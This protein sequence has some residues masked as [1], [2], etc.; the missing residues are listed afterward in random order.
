ML[1]LA[2]KRDGVR[3]IMGRLSSSNLCASVS[4]KYSSGFAQGG[5]AKLVFSSRSTE[6]Q[7]ME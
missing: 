2:R 4:R 5:L 7:V 1:S 3:G 6:E